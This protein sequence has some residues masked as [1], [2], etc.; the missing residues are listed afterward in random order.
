M[1]TDIVGFTKLAQENESAALELLEVQR[2]SLRPVFARH[3]GREVKTIGDAFLVEFESALE[4]TL[5][6]VEVQNTIHRMA[7]E[8]GQDLKLRIGV[9]LGDVIHKEND[10]LGTRSMSLPASNRSLSL[11][12]S[13][14]QS[15][16]T[17]ISRTR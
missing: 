17:I 6:A 2:A 16:C 8:K 9:H 1:F 3:G 7:L 4:A 13:A 11:E 5:C 10:I 12:G 14:S 15:R